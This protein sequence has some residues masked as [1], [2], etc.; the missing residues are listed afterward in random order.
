VRVALTFNTFGIVSRVEPYE[1]AMRAAELEPVRNPESMDGLAG[2]LL[3]GGSDVNPK[4][5]GQQRLRHSDTPDDLRDELE[6]RL[7]REALAARLPVLGICRGMQLLNVF[8]GGTLIQHLPSSAVHRQKPKNAEHGRHPAAHRVHVKAGTRLAEIIG[9]GDHEVNSRH[10]QGADRVAE[11][12]IVSATAEDGVVEA[13]ELPDALFAIAVQWHPEDRVGV[14]E[15][16]RRLFEA[17]ALAMAIGPPEATAGHH[18]APRS[19]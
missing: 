15:I 6:M 18:A 1:A 5:Y 11:G 3:S 7:L 17:F 8:R 9:A 4:H 10:H 13:L 16:D 19:S 12:L 2:L 14:S